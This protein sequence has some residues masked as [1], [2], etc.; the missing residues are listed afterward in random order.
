M[1]QQ[2][3]ALTQEITAI[4][5]E[6]IQALRD[7]PRLL[8]VNIRFRAVS[9]TFDISVRKSLRTETPRFW[10]DITEVAIDEDGAAADRYDWESDML[11][12][13]TPEAALAS[14]A[15]MVA[16]VATSESGHRPG[17]QA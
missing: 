4:T 6:P 14:A 2:A 17:F 15:D 8:G 12:Y 9:R 13:D 16:R 1:D 11:L 5:R 10:W 3:E 7:N